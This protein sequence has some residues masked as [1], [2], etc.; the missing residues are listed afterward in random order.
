MK[1]KKSLVMAKDTL[2]RLKGS[3]V[4]KVAVVMQAINMLKSVIAGVDT[5]RSKA[6]E[7]GKNAKESVYESTVSDYGAIFMAVKSIV[8]NIYGIV[9]SF[10]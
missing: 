10:D 1:A 2:S 7:V 4:D 5:C 9:V 6:E 3:D 8:D